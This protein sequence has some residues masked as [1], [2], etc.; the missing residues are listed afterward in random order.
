[1]DGCTFPP[2]Q[3]TGCNLFRF[4]FFFPMLDVYI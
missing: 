3:E 1:M 2:N 4:L